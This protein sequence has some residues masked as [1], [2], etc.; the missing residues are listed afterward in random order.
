MKV[1]YR[2]ANLPIASK[3]GVQNELKNNYTGYKTAL[4][5]NNT[6]YHASI[7][8]IGGARVWHLAKISK[9]KAPRLYDSY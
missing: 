6:W 8:N 3:T 1:T 4:K 5:I 9:S 2:G 7:C